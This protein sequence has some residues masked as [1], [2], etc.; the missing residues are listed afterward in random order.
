MIKKYRSKYMKK[1][2][3]QLRSTNST[4][5]KE[6]ILKDNVDNEELKRILKYTYDHISYTYGVT[7]ASFL[8][9]EEESTINSTLDDVLTK[10]A[11]REVTGHNALRLCKGYY[12]SLD[13]DSKHMFC[14]VIDRDLKIGVSSRT[15]NK[16]WKNLIPKPNYCRCDIFNAK[17]AKNVNYPAFI[18]LK[19]DGTYREAY[20]HN[21][22]VTFKTRAGETYENPILAEE[23]KTLPN[24][25][26]TGEFTIGKADEPDMNRSEGNGNIN[27]DNPDFNNI[28]FTVWDM[29][30]EDEYAL[31]ECRNYDERLIDMRLYIEKLNSSLVHVVPS[32]K[33]YDIEDA[34]KVTSDWMNKGLEG[35]VLKS[36]NM[37]FKNGTS[38]EQ[39]KIKLK[40]DVEVRCTGFLEGTKGTKYE[41]KNKVITFENDEGTIKGQCS[42]MTDSMVEEVTKNPEKYIGKVLTVQF[43]DL[44]KSDNNE[45]Y[46]L[47]HPRFAEWRDDKN[48]TD[49]LEKTI[50]LRDMARGLK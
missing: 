11:T 18:Q 38:K 3:E 32:F 31:K 22:T 43:N 39:L 24:G 49:T 48:E 42:G 36:F 14:Q 45:Y 2:F 33:V 25:Y 6:S 8:K 27:S 41:G 21:G 17:T 29:L 50:Q 7:S 47:S 23:M 40:V 20:I 28:H 15:L 5:T 9:F 26:Y 12:N 37:K 19:C 16:I 10:L 46:A 4:K 13:D 34:L 30:T 35:G 44:S 1:I